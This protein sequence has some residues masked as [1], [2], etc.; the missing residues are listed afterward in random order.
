MTAIYPKISLVACM[1][2]MLT[3]ILA[4][5]TA[6]AESSKSHNSAAITPS[7]Q[8]TIE[9]ETA[10]DPELRREVAIGFRISPVPL[11]L[12]RKDPTLVGLGSYLVNAIGG[13]NDC[14]TNP[15]YAPGHNPFLGEHKRIYAKGYLA[16]GQNFGGGI[17]SRNLTPEHGLPAG[18]TFA[19]FVTQMRTGADLDNQGQLLQVMPWP[20]YQSMTNRD[21]SAIYTFL[22]AIPPRHID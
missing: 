16:G 10:G 20:T 22:S 14:H 9:A 17:I 1:A 6:G 7:M 8:A 12:S 4:P 15:S 19:E 5:V 13:C 3:F 18:R 21:L 11:D 2:F